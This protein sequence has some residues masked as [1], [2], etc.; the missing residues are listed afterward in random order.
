MPF[1]G[2]RYTGL[3]N[4]FND[5][6]A[7]RVIDPLDWNELFTDIES[8]INRVASGIAISLETF[9][10]DGEVFDGDY[11]NSDT[12]EA[13]LTSPQLAF[14]GTLVL[15]RPGI[16]RVTRNVF[17][18]A[19]GGTTIEGVRPSAYPAQLTF[20]ALTGS[21]IFADYLTDTDTDLFLNEASGFTLKNVGLIDR[22]FTAV[23]SGGVFA[24]VSNTP[25]MIRDY[26]APFANEGAFYPHYENV[27]FFGV[28][29]FHCN[30]GG[31]GM[32]MV[33]C[34]GE[35]FTI[36]T[37][38]SEQFEFAK[39]SRIRF[40]TAFISALGLTYNTTASITILIATPGVISG[41][42]LSVGAPFQVTTTGA[43]PTGVTAGATFYKL[44]GGRFATK[45]GGTPIDTSG[46]Q[47]GV[48]TIHTDYFTAA[49]D[50]KLQ[51]TVARE[52]QRCDRPHFD[53]WSVLGVNTDLLLTEGST[54][55]SVDGMVEVN[56][57]TDFVT[58]SMVVAASGA[59][60][61]RAN[62]NLAG[63]G[64]RAETLGLT[65]YGIRTTTAS[66]FLQLDFVN[67]RIQGV[68]RAAYAEDTNVSGHGNVITFGGNTFVDNYDINLHGYAALNALNQSV[69][70]VLGT[71]RFEPA[72]GSSA[73]N[74]SGN[75]VRTTVSYDSPE[76]FHR[77]GD[78]FLQK[79]GIAAVGTYD[80]YD[81]R[82]LG[83]A[84]D[85]AAGVGVFLDY[86]NGAAWKKAVQIANVASGFG[87]LKLMQDGGTV[88]LGGV[89]A[90]GTNKI[91][92][93]GDPSSAQDAATKAYVDA[94]FAA[95]DAMIFKGVIDAS[96]N[97][98]YP[99]ADRGHTYRISVAGKIGGASGT[100]VEAGDLIICLTDGTSAG[101]QGSVGSSW[102]IAQT[103]LDGAVIGPASATDNGF[104]RFDGTTGKLIKNSAA[105]ISNSDLAG[106]IAASKLIGSD[107]ATVGTVTA[108][109]WNAGQVTS[110]A[111]VRGTA[112][113]A[114]VAPAAP[115]HG[116]ASGEVGRIETPGDV[117]SSG[118]A[119]FNIYD[120]GG[121]KA[122]FGF[123]GISNQLDLFGQAGI[124]LAFKSGGGNTIIMGASQQVYTPGIG[125]TASAANA[126]LDFGSTPANQL[127]RS[128]SSQRYKR[129]IE[130]MD[131]ANAEKLLALR[132]VWY[133][134]S[135]KT[136]RQDWSHYGFIA[137]EVADI[138]P[139]LVHFGYRE[140]DWDTI[141]VETVTEGIDGKPVVLRTTRAELKKG[142]KK[143]PN[144]VAY[145][146]L[147]VPLFV[148]VQRLHRESQDLRARIVAL[149]GRSQ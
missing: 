73:P 71:D 64:T 146:R 113:G 13:A 2:G 24:P 52:L 27:D 109:V 132:P 66:A 56:C 137:E 45:P 124:T 95:N 105:Q 5:A 44:S 84:S 123:G 93:M 130:D 1:S 142:A 144:S 61:Q 28:G 116:K 135:I 32:E 87:N 20:S 107:I 25:W 110:S 88:T 69:I 99:A 126:F 4:S 42:G 104:A 18:V 10:A 106:S 139:R 81:L 138:D 58:N 97:P 57:S 143:V 134:S 14:G 136:D 149:E 96:S 72:A 98:N 39:Y 31:Y 100:N 41:D 75:V 49:M 120:S 35:V 19:V 47:S 36:G 62:C 7:G 94:S 9:K 121:Q 65:G 147:T 26:R 89:V 78:F 40:N 133:R 51:N 54:V 145:D 85:G 128:T 114:G 92:G 23:P 29:K 48:H 129:D 21:W 86:Y 30:D 43:L 125:T 33:G 90:M 148:L 12:V 102:T 80:A 131:V 111:A 103:N 55:G 115:L 63:I 15:P 3:A 11:D 17:R 22:N 8:A 38:Q 53:N 91:T 37:K 74:T 118:A 68:D 83:G 46:S 67:T 79:G 122:Y 101:T 112:V 127:L 140:E 108:G 117:G 141:P 59:R 16:V 70:R 60:I 50:Y 76:F 6:V 77:G 82:L 119:Y 34:R